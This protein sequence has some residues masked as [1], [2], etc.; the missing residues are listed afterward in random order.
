MFSPGIPTLQTSFDNSSLS[1]YKDCPRKYFYAIIEG[2][3]PTSESAA[4]TFG[5]LYHLGMETLARAKASGADHET[6]VRCMLRKVIPQT[7]TLGWTDNYRNPYTLLRT[8][9]WYADH[10][11]NDPL[12]TV[13]LP[14]DKPALELSF[15]FELP[16]K[17]P[18]D[19]PYFYCG[20][21]DRIAR[22]Q[23]QTY[24]ID[25]KTTTSALT[26]AYF[27]RYN[28]NAQISGYSYAAQVLFM[29]PASGFIID[30]MQLGVNFNRPQRYIAP[31]THEQLDEWLEN[32]MA[33][34]KRIEHSAIHNSW[35]MN[36]E[37]CTK[38]GS[39]QFREVC[40]KT[41]SIRDNFLAS[42][43]RRDRWNPLEPR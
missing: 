38:Y 35:P 5:T 43:F 25:Y 37:S 7:E 21:I 39:C 17:T 2:W 23:G 42:G 28:P 4:L 10:Y 1:L 40:N 13:M 34:I 18:S 26:D 27:A 33:W 15:R 16:I 20:H 29:Q 24:C 22:M 30:A 32:T 11:R 41:P 14:G 12:Q 9:V 8:L 3:R 19:E 36:E 31:R 6:A